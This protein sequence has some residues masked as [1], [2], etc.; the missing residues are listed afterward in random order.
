MPVLCAPHECCAVHIALEYSQHNCLIICLEASFSLILLKYFQALKIKAT[1]ENLV[2][3]FHHFILNVLV[4]FFSIFLPRSSSSPLLVVM[5]LELKICFT[6]YVGLCVCLSHK[7][8]Q[9]YPNP[10]S[11]HIVIAI[12]SLLTVLPL[13]SGC[14]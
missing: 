12:L 2:S 5:I 9:V 13:T 10:C 7:A 6:V 4:G 3:N 8:L 11:R 1:F 14:Y